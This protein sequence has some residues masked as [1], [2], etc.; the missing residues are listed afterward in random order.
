MDSPRLYQDLHP[1]LR[2]R[3][4]LRIHHTPLL[5]QLALRNDILVDKQRLTADLRPNSFVHGRQEECIHFLERDTLR[6]GHEEKAPDTHGDKNGRKEEVR[7]VSEVADHVGR[8]SGDDEATE[9]GVCGGEGDAEHADIE[10]ED[11]GRVR[12][13]DTL[14]SGANDERVDVHTHHSKVAPAIAVNG[15]C[16]SGSGRVGFHDVP[17]DVP[18]GDASQCGAPDESLT[19][20]NTFNDDEGEGAHAKGLCDAIEAGGEELEG[21]AGDT[22]GFKDARG[23][24][25]DDVDL[26]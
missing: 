7:A 10:R 12:P 17:A 14:P 4:T 26:V 1:S 13:C 23:V 6:L 8:G 11:L 24:V 9:P 19:A 16:G 3:H 21:C 18:H 25:G 20:T 2:P 5:S 22:K 15:A